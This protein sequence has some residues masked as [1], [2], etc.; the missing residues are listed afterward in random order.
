MKLTNAQIIIMLSLLILMSITLLIKIFTDIFSG[1]C[2]VIEDFSSPTHKWGSWADFE[3]AQTSISDGYMYFSPLYNWTWINF[4]FI[5]EGKKPLN[6]SGYKK[7]IVYGL[8]ITG[9]RAKILEHENDID[10][11]GKGVK[12]KNY[13]FDLGE[14][15]YSFEFNDPKEKYLYSIGVNTILF[16]G[17]KRIVLCK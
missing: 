6:I 16:A 8:G 12:D 17:V 7:L 15:R 9:I 10:C 14:K 3:N 4:C 1:D 5:S 13:P 2:M 11:G